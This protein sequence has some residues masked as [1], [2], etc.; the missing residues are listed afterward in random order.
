MN[1]ILDMDETLLSAQFN[2]TANLFNCLPMFAKDIKPYII[3]TK[4]VHERPFLDVFF[5]YVFRK[6]QRVSI[7]THGTSNWYCECY[8][9]VL[10][11]FIPYGK[12]FHIVI[13]RDNGIIPFRQDLSK[14]LADLYLYNPLYNENNTLILDDKPYTYK[15]NISNSIFI[16]PYYLSSLC[17]DKNYNDSE[18]L[19]VIQY[20]EKYLFCK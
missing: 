7:W 6:F 16:E 8:E 2:A 1:I 18:L 9:K 15:Y 11:Q 12:R 20:L 5:E 10:K 13:T 4:Q 17:G 14:Q 19:R 3:L